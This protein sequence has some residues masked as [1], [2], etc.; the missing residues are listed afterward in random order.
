MNSIIFD[1][2]LSNNQ[3]LL[4]PLF[5][6]FAIQ[7]VSLNYIQSLDGT[8]TSGKKRK[9]RCATDKVYVRFLLLPLHGAGLLFSVPDHNSDDFHS[10]WGIER[11]GF[12]ISLTMAIQS[13]N[14]TKFS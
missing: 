8:E 14:I 1:S 6:L 3:L 10:F 12:L 13:G 9:K 4:T 11:M 2:I 5:L 7:S